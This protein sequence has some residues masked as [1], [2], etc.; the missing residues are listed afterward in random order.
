MI[1]TEIFEENFKERNNKK[2]FSEDFL[3]S[4]VSSTS[5]FGCMVSTKVLQNKS[6]VEYVGTKT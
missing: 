1:Q 2:Y 6:K 4:L 3:E 5:V